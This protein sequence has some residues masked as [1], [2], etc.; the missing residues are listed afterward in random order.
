[1]AKERRRETLD[2]LVRKF[3]DWLTDSSIPHTL[4]EVKG[5]Y[6]IQFTDPDEDLKKLLSSL[7][8]TIDTGEE[9]NKTAIRKPVNIFTS[10]GDSIVIEDKY[11]SDILNTL[12]PAIREYIVKKVHKDWEG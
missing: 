8:I 9:E 12:Y 6:V 10:S 3:S 1:M 11:T 7:F 2:F 4:T 5:G